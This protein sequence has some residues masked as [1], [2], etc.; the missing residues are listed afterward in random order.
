MSDV[1]SITPRNL[2][3]LAVDGYCPRAAFSAQGR[4]SKAVLIC[5]L[6]RCPQFE[7]IC[8]KDSVTSAVTSQFW[9]QGELLPSFRWRIYAPAKHRSRSIAEPAAER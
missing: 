9:Q 7:R 4:H 2:G 5:R 6:E 1:L 3:A 8:R